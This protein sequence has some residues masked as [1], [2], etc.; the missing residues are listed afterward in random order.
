MHT[1][2]APCRNPDPCRKYTVGAS[3]LKNSIRC[4]ITCLP[5]KYPSALSVRKRN[6]PLPHRRIKSAAAV[7][8]YIQCGAAPGSHRW[9]LPHRP[10]YAVLHSTTSFFHQ[11]NIS[12][13]AVIIPSAIGIDREFAAAGISL[14]PTIFFVKT[15]AIEV[16]GVTIHRIN[17]IFACSGS[18]SR[19]QISRET[20]A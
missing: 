2:T 3:S 13:S 20:I 17:T 5:L 11:R 15:G 12:T 4:G 7:C 10:S 16:I 9:Q 1:H 14:S 19:N 18:G 8:P 6:V